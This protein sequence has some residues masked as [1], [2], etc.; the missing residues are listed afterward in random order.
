MKGKYYTDPY[1]KSGDKGNTSFASAFLNP[2]RQGAMVRASGRK[3][4]D[5]RAPYPMNCHSCA[6]MTE[7]YSRFTEKDVEKNVPL[8]CS[9]QTT[10]RLTSAAQEMN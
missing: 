3:D 5:P 8:L 7:I 9:K 6:Q 4:C 2:R 1:I 10:S